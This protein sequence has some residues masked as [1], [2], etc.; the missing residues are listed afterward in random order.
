MSGLEGE[1]AEKLCRLINAYIEPVKPVA[2]E[3]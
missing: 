3:I 1:R 2:T